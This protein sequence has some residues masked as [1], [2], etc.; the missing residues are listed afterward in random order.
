MRLGV[1]VLLVLAF[2]VLNCD[3]WRAEA[4][5]PSL[6][7]ILQGKVED[8]ETH[9]PIGGATVRVRRIIIGGEGLADRE[10][11][12]ETSLKTDAL[13]R[14]KVVF[15]CTAGFRPAA[16]SSRSP[17]L[18]RATRSSRRPRPPWRSSMPIEGKE[19]GPPSGRSGWSGGSNIR[20]GYI[21]LTATPRS[22]SLTSSRR[23]MSTSPPEQSPSSRARS[24]AAPTRADG[25]GCAQ[26][27]IESIHLWITPIEWAP[28]HV[29]WEGDERDHGVEPWDRRDLGEHKLSRGFAITGR[30]LDLKG[31]PLPWQRLAAEDGEGIYG[32]TA[33]TDADG[34]FAFAPLLPGRYVVRGAN[35]RSTSWSPE[36]LSQ[37]P[38]DASIKPVVAQI[39]ARPP[40]RPDRAPR[41]R[42][43]DRRDPSR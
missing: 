9:E 33:E 24:E 42:S 7:L 22:A 6:A 29:T 37:S 34:R 25:F 8:E 13:G 4:E 11:P 16:F 5:P 40:A 14:V 38:S 41:G 12:A 43:R 28:R 2:F 20:R 30:L 10:N 17:S 26:A 18:T 39:Q 35:Q 19:I 21:L 36:T 27:D 31:R 32:R 1:A 3:P 15:S 23:A